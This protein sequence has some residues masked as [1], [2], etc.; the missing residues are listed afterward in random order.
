MNQEKETHMIRTN[1]E[2]FRAVASAAAAVV[3]TLTITMAVSW[4]FMDTARVAR[5]H[6][7]A[8]SAV[9]PVSALVR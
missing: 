6:Y 5:A 1:T 9:V 3:I 2:N 7:D 8:V 4:M